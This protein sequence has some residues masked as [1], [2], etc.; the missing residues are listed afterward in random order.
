MDIG[1][2][3]L[4]KND[5]TTKK[6]MK[7]E[8]QK[9]YKGMTATIEYEI[10]E[11]NRQ[12]VVNCTLKYPAD[13][14]PRDYLSQIKATESI[15]SRLK[16]DKYT[17][18]IIS[19]KCPGYNGDVITLGYSGE[20]LLSENIDKLNQ[21]MNKNID[22]LSLE[23]AAKTLE[24]WLSALNTDVRNIQFYKVRIEGDDLYYMFDVSAV[25]RGLFFVNASDGFIST[26]FDGELYVPVQYATN[27]QVQAVLSFLKS[28][29]QDINNIHNVKALLIDNK[30][31]DLMCD[32]VAGT[33]LLKDKDGK[34]TVEQYEE[35]H[36][37]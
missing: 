13:I 30:Y 25:N 33:Y 9:I 11:L 19:M 18:I 12:N 24:K 5:T 14:D 20:I 7:N 31:I 35:F 3:K 32:E 23:E 27:D 6:R 16:D 29:N 37:D 17:E 1:N 15:I 2:V 21:I 8:I 36:G 10:D 28:N 4:D 34:V 22:Y 26:Y